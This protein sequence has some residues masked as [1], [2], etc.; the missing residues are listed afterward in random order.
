MVARLYL[1]VGVLLVVS[2][3]I[4]LASILGHQLMYN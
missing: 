3:A 2:W 4:S 1:K